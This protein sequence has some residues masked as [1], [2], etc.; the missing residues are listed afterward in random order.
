MRFVKN[1]G[2]REGAKCSREARNVEFIQFRNE[3]KKLERRRRVYMGEGT[4]TSS[5]A[6]CGGNGCFRRW[7]RG[8]ALDSDEVLW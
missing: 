5:A 4:T 3:Y 2:L 7:P 8:L 1:N 6:W